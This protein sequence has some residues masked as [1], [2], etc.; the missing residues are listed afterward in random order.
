MSNQEQERLRRLR[1]RQ[2]ADRDPKVKERQFQRMTAQRE[3]KRDKS[4]SL[5]RAWGD[6]PHIWR[7]SFYGLLVGLFIMLVLP[8]FWDSSWTFL[9][10]V[11]ATI[12]TTMFGAVVGNAID[13]REELKNLMR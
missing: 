11:L 10:S 7:S 2:L 3:Q 1:E 8:Y 13:A 5:A 4:Y 6:I 12:V 9:V